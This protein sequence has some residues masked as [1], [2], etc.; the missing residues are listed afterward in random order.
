MSDSTEN[1]LPE[2]YRTRFTTLAK[3]LPKYMALTK[4]ILVDPDVPAASKAVLGASG[5]YAISPIDIIPGFIP[6][7]GQLDDAW[8]LLV[9]VRKSLRSMPPELAAAHMSKA[10]ISWQDIEDD[11]ALVI[12][13]AKRIGRL[14]ITTGVHI[15]RAGRATF[16]FA[17]D[18][19][20]G[21]ASKAGS[22]T[23]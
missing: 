15:G 3:R 2:S 9:G 16:R 7:A 12:S 8:V 14:V 23:R 21:I 19:F 4:Q 17:S 11:I 1:L 18:T 10:E 5:A 20:R 13:L 22:Q 6:V